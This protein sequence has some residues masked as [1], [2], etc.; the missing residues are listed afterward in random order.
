VVYD[1]ALYKSTF[2]L[3]YFTTVVIKGLS[4]TAKLCLHMLC[5]LAAEDPTAVEPNVGSKRPAN[6]AVESVKK[7]RQSS[8]TSLRHH[9]LSPA[10]QGL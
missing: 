6:T 4:L 9:S 1:D 3:L 5:A 8:L 2:T 10:Q 7:T